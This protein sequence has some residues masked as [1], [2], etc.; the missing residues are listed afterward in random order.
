MPE[1]QHLDAV[2]HEAH[3]VERQLDR[4]QRQQSALADRLHR[5]DDG[6]DDRRPAGAIGPVAVRHRPPCPA[7]PAAP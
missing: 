1:L 4:G 6:L 5:D 7:R 2:H 3:A